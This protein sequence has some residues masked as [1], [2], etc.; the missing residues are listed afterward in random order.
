MNLNYYVLTDKG[1]HPKNEDA[2]QIEHIG[3]LFVFALADGIG[4]LPK[5][6][7]AATLAVTELLHYIHITG[8]SDLHQGFDKVNQ[9]IYNQGQQLETC[10]ATTLLACAINSTTGE[11]TI[12]HVG[13]SRA[14]IFGSSTWKTKD[15][16][17]VQE[18]VE[19]G[20]LTENGAFCHPEK[21]RLKQAIGSRSTIKPDIYE[22]LLDTDS[23]IVLCTDGVHDYVKNDDIEIIALSNTPKQVCENLIDLARSLGNTDDIT[24]LTIHYEKAQTS[25][26]KF[27]RQPEKNLYV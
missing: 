22:T 25:K 1:N 12:A 27:T 16:S 4:S 9:T 5:A 6:D 23:I 14:Y 8:I 7:I 26:P 15:H 3:D 2:Y 18:L 10:M 24:I 13:D 11:C 17:L 21:H 20:I 19:L